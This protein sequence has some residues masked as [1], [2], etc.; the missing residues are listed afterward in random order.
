MP[1]IH[2]SPLATSIAGASGTILAFG[3][4]WL[5]ARVLV[6]RAGRADPAGPRAAP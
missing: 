3:L 2:W 6:P 5:L 4:A 1:G